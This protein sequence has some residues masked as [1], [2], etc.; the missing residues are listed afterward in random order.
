MLHGYAQNAVIFRKRLAAF[1]KSCGE[2]IEL[3]FV[4]AP[5]VLDPVD[6]G[7]NSSSTNT[8]ESFDAPEV[9]NDPTLTPRGWWRK[10]DAAR[11]EYAG[12]DASLASLRNVLS[13]ERYVGVLGFSQGA[14]MAA[15]LAALL[16]NP[17]LQPT[18]LINGE[19]LHPPF[20]FCVAVSGFKPSG[21]ICTSLFASSYSTP[22]LHV[23]GKT[24]VVVSEERSKTL[25]NV[26]S[27]RR[28]EWHD[29]G[30][31]VPSKKQWR[32]FLRAYILNPTDTIASPELHIP[33]RE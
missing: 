6:M 28:V 23:L 19:P 10:A 32:A 15:V 7:G 13:Q 16:E 18:F 22:T 21:P 25:L 12:L 20:Q 27:N 31:C 14:A 17:S 2:D 5:H 24:D 4:D 30:H 8:L 11:G 9:V 26:S 33:L 3:V 1:R 29:G